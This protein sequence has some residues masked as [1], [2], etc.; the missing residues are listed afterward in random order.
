METYRNTT[1]I[2]W[3]AGLFEGEGCISL[4]H[5]SPM[6]QLGTTDLDVLRRFQRA[7]G[8]GVIS[9]P[10]RPR[11]STKP[12]WAWRCHGFAAVQALVAMFWSWLGER[13]KAR[14]M[15]VLRL[16]INK[17]Y[18]GLDGTHWVN[19]TRRRV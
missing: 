1:E 8:F 11:F 5:R 19:G 13:R 14:T 3:A 6:A 4:N 12:Y 9:P 2:S 7:V 18:H 17:P 10:R 15:E 16:W